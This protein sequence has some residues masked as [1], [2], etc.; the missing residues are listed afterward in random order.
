MYQDQIGVYIDFEKA[1]MNA[2][3]S[4]KKKNKKK[5]LLEMVILIEYRVLLGNY[6][7][8]VY[9]ICMKIIRILVHFVEQF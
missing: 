4:I 9:L 1:A 6:Y 2:V 3:R 8:S 7:S 5:S